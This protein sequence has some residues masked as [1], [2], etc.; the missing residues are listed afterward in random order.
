[1]AKLNIAITPYPPWPSA[2][3]DALPKTER[4][5]AF[6]YEY[7]RA[8]PNVCAKI[9]KW[10]A[11]SPELRE[12]ILQK[13]TEILG[14]D[15]ITS[16]NS[17][18][19]EVISFGN[20]WNKVTPKRP[21]P[22]TQPPFP[23]EFLATF[24]QFPTE[25]WYSI[26][27][28]D[29]KDFWIHALGILGPQVFDL[30]S[31][32]LRNAPTTSLWGPKGPIIV[33]DRVEK[34]IIHDALQE[35]SNNGFEIFAFACDLGVFSDK[36]LTKILGQ[37]VRRRRQQRASKRASAKMHKQ[38]RHYTGQKLA[39]D[40]FRALH[41]LNLLRYKSAQNYS[42][43]ETAFSRHSE[44]KGPKAYAQI[45]AASRELKQAKKIIAWFSGEK[46]APKFS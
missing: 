42:L 8:S 45:S 35:F 12:L 10:T 11:R 18:L 5:A 15:G 32:L 25:P 3:L 27:A 36:E 4:A 30:S 16:V 34:A 2:T 22:P 14:G 7:A 21:Q 29:Q 6:Y 23:P 17:D 37:A 24:P 26:P 38:Q 44:K 20:P 13:I 33:P 19:V 40:P 9:Q 46:A 39:F 41:W 1:M 31:F 28:S 43:K